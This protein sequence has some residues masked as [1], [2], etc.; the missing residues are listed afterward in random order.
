MK[1]KN[2]TLYFL[3]SILGSLTIVFLCLFLS[4]WSTSNSYKTQLENIYE[5]NFY[6]SV[7]TINNLEVDISKLVATNDL[8]S[9][10]ELLN[11]INKS[12]LLCANNINLLPISFNNMTDINSLVN[13]L[14]GFSESLLIS[15]YDGDLIS[16]S[17][18]SQL[19]DMHTKIQEMQYDM[20]MY[21]SKLK[22]DYSILDDVDFNDVENNSYTGG[23]LN[24]E[25][26]ATEI[27]TLIYDGPFS[28]SVL[29]KEI[30][31][32]ENIEY[33]KDECAEKLHTIFSG[34]SIDYLGETNGK[35]E[36]YNF[37]VKGDVDLYVS[38][39][40]KGGFILSITSF[41]NG[42]RKEN[43][44]SSEDGIKLA[45]SFAYDCGLENMYMVWS[46]NT[47]NILYV[48]LAPIE[49]GVIYYTDL[50][51]VKVDLSLGLVVGWEGVNYATNHIDREF[52]SSI[53]I[54]EGQ[55]KIN[56]LLN[57]IERNLCI[58]PGEYVGE[59]SA[60][61]YICTWKNYTYYIYIDSNTG[62][63]VNIMRVVETNNGSLLM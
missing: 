9:Q 53:G 63:E 52:T 35:F 51:K 49:D 17:D 16:E 39:T 11:S 25:S 46:Q 59:L 24:N 57:V 22:Y 55:E 12:C 1:K 36:T 38:V 56:P 10:R 13:S 8:D 48:N 61:E 60:Y 58:I 30:K 26:S 15:N 29:N 31:G 7:S 21:L 32:L 6:E 4:F 54:L 34:F 18:L 45:E 44:I 2:I 5:K 40:K 19:N 47:G 62:K 42:S 37:D 28:D 20:N 43:K 3:L 27:P 33:S 41:G 50:V 14:F 23:L